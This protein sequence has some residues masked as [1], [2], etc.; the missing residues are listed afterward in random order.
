M[1]RKPKITRDQ[2]LS[3]RPVAAPISGRQTL[4]NGGQRL[5]F[6]ARPSRWQKT[7][8]RLP[9]TVERQFELDPYG[10]EILDMCNSKLTVLRIVKRFADHHRLDPHEAERAVLLFLRMLVRKGLVT[11]L[12]KK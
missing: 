12:V 11:M 2:S 8:L 10:V 4:E 3:A 6:N 9:D 1:A 7:L 5:T